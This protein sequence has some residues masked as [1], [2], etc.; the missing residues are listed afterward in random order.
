MVLAI[1]P[2]VGS[3]CLLAFF[4]SADQCIRLFAVIC[5]PILDKT[6]EKFMFIY[7]ELDGSQRLCVDYH[8]YNAATVKDAFPLLQ[9]DDSLVALSGSRWF[10]MMLDLASSY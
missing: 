9:V 10:S 6:V 7:C 8:Q 1:F 3:L 2:V 4:K 5:L